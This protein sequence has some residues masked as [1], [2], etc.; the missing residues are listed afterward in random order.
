MPSECAAPNCREYQRKEN[1]LSFHTFPSNQNVCQQWLQKLNRCE[2]DSKGQLKPWKPNRHS[3]LCSKHFQFE[4][5]TTKTQLFMKKSIDLGAYNRV[6]HG[7]KKVLK[8]DAVPSIFPCPEMTADQRLQ[9]EER[10]MSH[11]KK[12]MKTKVR[13]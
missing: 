8:P 12:K 10:E 9:Q 11:R 6:K 13:K 7:Y 3:V 4:D 2:F 5:F 1:Q